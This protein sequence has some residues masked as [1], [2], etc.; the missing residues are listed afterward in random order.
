M[1]DTGD[2]TAAVAAAT[3]AFLIKSLLSIV[4]YFSSVITYY[5]ISPINITTKVRK[6]MEKEYLCGNF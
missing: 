5:L 4:V 2:T 3:V 1:N 6:M